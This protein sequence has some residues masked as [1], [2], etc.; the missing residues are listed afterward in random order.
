[1]GEAG[2]E[3]CAYLDEANDDCRSWDAD[4]SK[5]NIML[6]AADAIEYLVRKLEARESALTS[7]VGCLGNSTTAT[8]DVLNTTEDLIT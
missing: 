2:C 1:M 3:G 4:N 7:V 8:S 6:D 5:E